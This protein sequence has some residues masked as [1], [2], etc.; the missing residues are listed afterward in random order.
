MNEKKIAF[1][2]CVNNELEYA[3][4]LY[5][6]ERL[7]VPE[8]YETDIIAVREAP[9]MTAGYNAAMQ[10]SDA[11]YKVYLHQDTFIINQN[12]IIEMLQIFRENEQIGMLGCMGSEELPVHAQGVVAWDVG[13][14]YHNCNPKKQVGKQNPDG[15]PFMVEAL[16]GLLLAT[17]Y[18][19]VWREDIFDGWDYYD[20]SQCMEMLRAGYKVAVPYQSEPWCYHDNGYSKMDNYYR[21]C[22]KFVEEYQDI[23]PFGVV[24]QSDIN[25]EYHMLRERSRRELVQLVERGA[26]EELLGIFESQENC[27]YLHLR[28]FEVLAAIVKLERARGKSNFWKVEDTWSELLE[29]MAKIR[30]ALKRIEFITE[31]QEE[32]TVPLILEYGIEALEVLN[33]FFGVMQEKVMQV[34][35]YYS[36]LQK[37]GAEKMELLAK[38]VRQQYPVPETDKVSVGDFTYGA[39]FI[40]TSNDTAKACIGKF[41]SFAKDVTMLLEEDHRTEWNSTYPFNTWMEEFSYNK[42]HPTSKGDIIIGNDVWIA[43]NATI[44]SGVTIGDG[45]VVA[46]NT[47]VVKDV[48]P[49]SIVA[50]NPGRIVKMRFDEQTRARLL[51]MKWW[52]WDYEDIYN[53]IPILQSEQIDALY[54]YYITHVQSKNKSK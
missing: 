29:K 10:S 2:T 18:D 43:T 47:V 53:V 35:K 13:S 9:S 17:Q 21:Y 14:I 1:I 38:R 48:P 3:E 24:E 50:G 40:A 51:E 31:K 15:T 39:P 25:K 16:D 49:Y 5:Y 33:F 46:A 32:M 37:S 27:G 42:K 7:V 34:L 52:D 28:E 8:G 44:L 23:K 19:V 36:Y 4:T 6:I 54:D 30:F 11:K 41:C 45:A 26:R 20:I 12:F 22:E